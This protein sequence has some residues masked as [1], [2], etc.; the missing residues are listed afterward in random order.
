MNTHG[1]L[2]R[3][4]PVLGIL[5]MTS[6][7][8]FAKTSKDSRRFTL[9][10]AVTIGGAQV[11]AGQYNVRWVSHSPDATVT[12]EKGHNVVATAEAKWVDRPVKYE[13]NAAVIETNADGSRSIVEL[14]FAGMSEA[15]VFGGSSPSAAIV[16]P[17]PAALTAGLPAGFGP[18]QQIRF[19]GKA[20]TKPARA[21]Q[22]DLSE[23]LS[24][25]GLNGFK[26]PV[27]PRH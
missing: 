11:P 26:Q 19:V 15:L 12:F 20:A 9:S 6:V 22:P 4:A 23:V 14:R 5:I 18:T 2:K 8:V 25:S 1:F 16:P 27:M 3:F 10:A 21:A 24:G 7:T 13:Q 17:E